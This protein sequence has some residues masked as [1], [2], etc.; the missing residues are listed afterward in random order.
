MSLNTYK[1]NLSLCLEPYITHLFANYQ[2]KV[3]EDYKTQQLFQ[4]NI[5]I[6]I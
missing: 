3:H 6:F 5:K 2:L 4:G 1:A